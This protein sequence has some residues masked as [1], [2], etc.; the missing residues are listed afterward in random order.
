MPEGRGWRGF[1]HHAALCVA[2][3]GFLL[4]ERAAIPPSGP[5]SAWL[6]KT[7][8]FPDAHRPRGTA[9]PA[10][11]S[12]PAFDRDPAPAHRPRP[13]TDPAAMS[14]LCTDRRF[15]SL[16]KKPS[17]ALSQ[18]AEVT[19]RLSEVAICCALFADILRP[20]LGP[21]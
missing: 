18:E 16:A 1:H 10:R 6:V 7:P 4:A 21:T 13:R 9:A 14:V 12:H 20:K 15:V 3:Y 19:F 17:T 8:V 5:G 2:A 11:A